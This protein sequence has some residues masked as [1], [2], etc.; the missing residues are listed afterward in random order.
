MHLGG[1]EYLE[2]VMHIFYLTYSGTLTFGNMLGNSLPA[3]PAQQTTESYQNT[4]GCPQSR[5]M[6]CIIVCIEYSR[7]TS[8]NNFQWH[9]MANFPNLST[10]MALLSSVNKIPEKS[11]TISSAD[12]PG[13]GVAGQQIRQFRFRRWLLGICWQ[14]R[15]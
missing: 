1:P 5:N 10:F 12:W 11:P 3:A 6:F 14:R 8:G 9:G 2:Y 4:P 15:V 13:A 7:N